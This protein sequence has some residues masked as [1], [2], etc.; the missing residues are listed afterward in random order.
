MCLN[1]CFEMFIKEKILGNCTPSTITFYEYTILKLISFV[2]NQQGDLLVTNLHQY[3]QP[4]FLALKDNPNL[5]PHSY[6]TLILGVKIF[7]RALFSEK[8]IEKGRL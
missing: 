4:Y 7:T 1:Q 5:S 8:Y 6:N 3:S 2:E